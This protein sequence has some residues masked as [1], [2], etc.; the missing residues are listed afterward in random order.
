V[1][2]ESPNRCRSNEITATRQEM[3][4]SKED[5]ETLRRQIYEKIF[6]GKE[7]DRN[8]MFHN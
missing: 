1:H 2:P 8:E 7:L 3:T 6:K 4:L 5:R